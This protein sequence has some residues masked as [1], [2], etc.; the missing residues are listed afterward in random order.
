MLV[1]SDSRGHEEEYDYPEDCVEMPSPYSAPRNPWDQRLHDMG[2][3]QAEIQYDML[4]EWS[5]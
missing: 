2:W 4:S 5:E 1:T 3:A